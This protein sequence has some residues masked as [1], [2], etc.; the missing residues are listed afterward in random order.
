MTEIG[1]EARRK[2]RLNQIERVNQKA[3]QVYEKY[4]PNP[5][6]VP[7][8]ERFYKDWAKFIDDI[9][10]IFGRIGDYRRAFNIGVKNVL[11]YQKRHNWK[12]NP[13]SYIVTKKV[14]QATTHTRL[15]AECMERL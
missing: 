8:Q 1:V 3:Q 10:N 14:T 2:N 7:K 15:D 12:V 6:I 13:P 4:F 9:T 11:S 5:V